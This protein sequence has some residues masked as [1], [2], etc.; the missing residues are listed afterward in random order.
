MN[1]ELLK[2]ELAEF[3]VQTIEK[4][5]GRESV[6][7]D[8]ADGGAAAQ[9]VGGV[10]SG[11]LNLQ[12]MQEELDKRI[13]LMKAGTQEGRITDQYRVFEHITE[14]IAAGEYLRLIVQAS[15]GYRCMFCRLRHSLQ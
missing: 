13:E 5:R 3:T 15:A 9:S 10:I 6:V 11:K 2:P 7:N 8:A 1:D 14:K 4:E 12:Q